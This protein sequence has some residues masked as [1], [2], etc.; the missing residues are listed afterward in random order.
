MIE[1]RRQRRE[2]LR[3]REES[4]V[5]MRL[6]YLIR[7]EKQIE[8]IRDRPLGTEDI[9][10]TLCRIRNTDAWLLRY[11]LED[12]AEEAHIAALA[13]VHQDT[14]Q[15][16]HPVVL[17]NESADY[18]TQNLYPEF[19]AYERNLRKLL[20]M[21][22]T[23]C[24]DSDIT[25]KLKHLEKKTLTQMFELMFTDPNFVKEVG[26]VKEMENWY[27]TKD[28]VMERLEP[29]QEKTVW[30]SLIGEDARR[31]FRKK[32]MFLKQ[33][34]NKVMHAQDMEAEEF[35]KT[36]DM[37]REVNRQLEEE[38]G[39]V[40]LRTERD[41][42][43][44]Q[45]P[46]SKPGGVE[47][48]LTVQPNRTPWYKLKGFFKRKSGG[49]YG[50][51]IC[52]IGYKI[53]QVDV[54]KMRD[55][56]EKRRQLDASLGRLGRDL[57]MP[58]ESVSW[59]TLEELEQKTEKLR[60][61]LPEDGVLRL[62]LL[63]EEQDSD[64]QELSV[65][66]D[67]SAPEDLEWDGFPNQAECGC[68]VEV[69]AAPDAEKMEEQET[70][71]ADDVFSDFLDLGIGWDTEGEPV[72]DAE[73]TEEPEPER[74]DD[75]L[76]LGIAMG[77]GLFPELLPAVGYYASKNIELDERTNDEDQIDFEVDDWW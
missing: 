10:G 23:L 64:M 12:D 36:R 18:F 22:G 17:S 40:D 13:G 32:F 76:S 45:T 24:E 3:F 56:A 68:D 8:E 48:K 33:M 52:S 43:P 6:E 38:I 39:R 69:G 14:V 73:R 27:I 31:T 74:A 16:Y 20:Y 35:E 37:L 49:K 60:A 71:G 53:G 41:T 65:R 21:K 42:I 47:M 61:V 2:Q 26:K 30:N 46:D 7:D 55:L 11:E 29:C 28:E 75:A 77:L 62:D 58:E 15:Q 34:R 57:R 5:K 4:S 59:I 63:G 72:S 1:F 66:E 67:A 51:P 9:R 19:C 25:R 54:D 50:E 44:P 70:K